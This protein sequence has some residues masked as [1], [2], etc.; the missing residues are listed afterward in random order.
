MQTSLVAVKA[1][2]HRIL[3]TW[4]W[5]GTGWIISCIAEVNSKRAGENLCYCNVCL[6]NHIISTE[7]D[8]TKVLPTETYL[9]YSTLSISHFCMLQ[10]FKLFYLSKLLG[11]VVFKYADNPFHISIVYNLKF[12]TQHSKEI[13]LLYIISKLYLCSY[14]LTAMMQ[15]WLWI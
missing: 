1:I 3:A 10:S 5:D 7:C 11:N 2:R 9:T 8:T 14:T 6:S 13:A 15:L 12:Q 4:L